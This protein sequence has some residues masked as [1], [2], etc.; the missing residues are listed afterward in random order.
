MKPF[1]LYPEE[2]G[3]RDD[4]LE[5][6]AVLE[7]VRGDRTRLY[8]RLPAAER[9]NVTSSSDPFV[10]AVIFHALRAGADLVVHGP[11]SPSL[12]RWLEEFQAA[13]CRWR[14]DRYQPVSVTADVEREEA[15]ER[16]SRTVMTFSGGLDSCCTAWR[17]TKGNLVRR[18]RGLEA[19]VMVQG[20]DIPLEQMTPC[21][22][23]R[24]LR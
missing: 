3:E 9:H 23:S 18:K 10:L 6:P 7:G 19:A 20:F 14:P 16:V 4:Q 2:Y 13:W 12:L 22:S 15:R 8:F 5:V 11:V 1:H 21:S 24:D 17:Q